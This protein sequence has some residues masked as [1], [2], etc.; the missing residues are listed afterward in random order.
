MPIDFLGQE[1]NWKDA[2]KYCL[3]EQAE[4]IRKSW[5]DYLNEDISYWE[6]V[7]IVKKTLPG[8]VMI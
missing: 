5:D 8:I 2:Q 6:Y 7:K 4:I 1:L 3:P